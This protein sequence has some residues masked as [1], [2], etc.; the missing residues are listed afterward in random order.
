[1]ND[2]VISIINELLESGSDFVVVGRNDNVSGDKYANMTD[3]INKLTSDGLN[4][5]VLT[6]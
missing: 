1:M 3:S 5:S 4:I 6:F 2:N